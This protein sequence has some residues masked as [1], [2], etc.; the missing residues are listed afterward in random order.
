MFLGAHNPLPV[1]HKGTSRQHS[2]LSIEGML[3]NMLAQGT[4]C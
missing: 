1:I 2:K 4:F 3:T